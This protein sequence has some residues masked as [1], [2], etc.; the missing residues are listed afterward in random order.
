[1]GLTLKQKVLIVILIM[2]GILGLRTILIFGDIQKLEN[3]SNTLLTT[4]RQAAAYNS[5][6]TELGLAAGSAATFAATGRPTYLAQAQDALHSAAT[7]ITTQESLLTTLADPGAQATYHGYVQRQ[8][9]LLAMVGQAVTAIAAARQ[10]GD[11][12]ALGRALDSLATYEAPAA[13]LA[14]DVNATLDRQSAIDR[15]AIQDAGQG[16]LFSAIGALLLLFAIMVGVGL[17]TERG[18]IRPINRLSVAATTGGY[19]DQLVEITNRDEIGTLQRAFN[20]MVGNLRSVREQRDA[21]LRASLKAK[22]AAELANQAKSTFLANMSHELRTPLNAI[23]GFSELLQEEAA[24]LGQTGF[25]DHL[26]R[27]RTS[28][29]QLLGLVN[30]ILDLSKIEAGKMELYLEVFT[31]RELID[32]VVSTIHPL[33]EKNANTLE[34]QTP[35]DLGAM[36]ADQTKVRQV[37]LN[38]LSNAAKFTHHGLVTL[39]ISRETDTSGRW[40][41]FRV[42]DTGIGMRADQVQQLFREFWQADPSTTRRY[43]GTGLGLALSRH[44]CQLMEGDIQVESQPDVG[45]TFTVRLPALVIPDA[46]GAGALEPTRRRD[47]GPAPAARPDRAPAGTVLVIDD[48]P[49]ACDIIARFLTKA[50]F[51]IQVAANGEDGLR[52]A[53][54]LHPVAITLDVLMPNMDGWAVLTTL[55]ADPELADIPVLVLSIVDNPELGFSLGAAEYLIKPV[56]ADRLTAIVTRYRRTPPVVNGHPAGQILVVEDDSSTRDLLRHSLESDGW[57][58]VVAAD[59][60]AA[61]EQ[62][63]THPPDLVLLDLMLPG[64]DGFQVLAGLRQIPG[65]P[66]IPV[67]VLTARDLTPED[68]HRLNGYVEQILQKGSYTREELLRE[69]CDHVVARTQGREAG[70]PETDG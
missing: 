17:L 56:A 57:D 28:G 10:S 25:I 62:A 19:L 36:Y 32:Q 11:P 45:S 48:D 54:A 12:A 47:L 6:T 58:V 35:A 8:T 1:M 26:E 16:V 21:A 24:D 38:L 60:P 50:G 20:Q 9:D 68:H 7:P 42:T 3:A 64:M 46:G 59:G 44:F 13:Q 53:R 55:K 41:Q 49:A 18:I 27:I 14:K 5:F 66:A 15:Q 69:I 67:V 2:V 4:A 61:L 70:I 63:R 34:V 65:G 30:D 31:I 37:L 39:Q 23:I 40:I 51:G 43:G 33:I 22:E 29:G 52:L